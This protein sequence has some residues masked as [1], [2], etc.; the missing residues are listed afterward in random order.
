MWGLHCT[1]RGQSQEGQEDSGWGI[2]FHWTVLFLHVCS[3]CCATMYLCNPSQETWHFSSTT[4]RREADCHPTPYS[5]S[6]LQVYGREYSP[7]FGED[8]M[9]STLLLWGMRA[10]LLLS[11]ESKIL[12]EILRSFS[13]REMILSQ[14][15][16]PDQE[17]LLFG[18]FCFSGAFFVWVGGFFK[19]SA[20]SIEWMLLYFIPAQKILVGRDAV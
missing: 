1:H 17:W 6:C 11:Q 19:I 4:I 13:S 20:Y 16:F 3:G 14:S 12:I 15:F 9:Q 10:F 7:A 5:L 2:W 18:G 8:A